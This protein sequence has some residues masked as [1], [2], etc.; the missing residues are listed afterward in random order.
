MMEELNQRP[1]KKWFEDEKGIFLKW[2]FGCRFPN[3]VG[4]FPCGRCKMKTNHSSICPSM[5]G[6]KT[7]AELILLTGMSTII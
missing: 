1:R 7:T 3:G 5:C 4:G 2:S 6:T